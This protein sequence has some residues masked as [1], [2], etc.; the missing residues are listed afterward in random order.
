M[1]WAAAVRLM[2][3][4]GWRWWCWRS[5]FHSYATRG[6]AALPAPLVVVDHR[7]RLLNALVFAYYESDG[8]VNEV[9]AR[10]V[11]LVIHKTITLES[12]AFAAQSTV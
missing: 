9:A 11:C 2:M 6:I 3:L 4:R 5:I 1:G 10:S 7:L 8:T 12:A